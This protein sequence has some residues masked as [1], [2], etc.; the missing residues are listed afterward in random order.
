MP[1]SYDGE[2]RTHDTMDERTVYFHLEQM[3]KAEI[4]FILMDQTNN[5][6]VGV[7]SSISVPCRRPGR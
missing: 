7:D 1:L 5:I 6:D 3:A 4:D 2:Y